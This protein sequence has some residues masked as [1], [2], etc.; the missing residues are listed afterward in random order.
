MWSGL[1]AV[2]FLA[3]EIVDLAWLHDLPT[4]SRDAARLFRVL[5]MSLTATVVTAVWILWRRIP[6]LQRGLASSTERAAASPEQRLSLAQWYFGLRWVALVVLTAVIVVATTGRPHVPP[7]SILP[8]WAAT[9]VLLFFDVGLLFVPERVRARPSVLLAQVIADVLL[10]S[11]L[12]HHAGG[13]ANPFASFLVF[14][15]VIASIVLDW[16]RARIATGVTVGVIV[17]QAVLESTGWAPPACVSGIGA[18]CN[19]PDPLHL[20]AAG[21]GLATLSAGCALFTVTLVGTLARERDQL[22]VARADL[23]AERE[24]LQSI[25]A[26]MADAVIFADPKGRVLMHN[27]AAAKLFESRPGAGEDLK[28]CHDEEIWALL[29]DKLAHPASHEHHPVLTLDDR[30]YEATYARVED[31]QGGLAGVVM[32]ARDITERQRAQEWRMRKERMAVVGKLAAS[33]AHEINNPLGAIVL[34]TQHAL[35]QTPPSDPVFEHLSTVL[36]NANQASKIVRDLLTYARQRPPERQ[37]FTVGDLVREVARTLRHSADAAEV[38]IETK[39]DD[40][41][42]DELFGDPD[43]LRQVLVNLGLNAIDAMRGHG[44][45]LTL[46]VAPDGPDGIRLIV[47]DEGPG[48]AEGDREKVFQAFYTTKAE[49]TGLG[50]AV[51]QDIARA[52]GGT[53]E[54]ESE[55]GAGSTFSVRLPRREMPRASEVAA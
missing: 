26:C 50:L 23:S 18:T 34:F 46:G 36:S 47:A 15:A 24:K 11:W 14:H 21:V 10:L 27:R 3:Y 9:A 1:M 39:L 30:A 4:D 53:L 20:A 7:S 2:L 6:S 13:L 19:Q 40:E 55:V 12:L 54:L 28:V 29:L 22:F 16:R 43:Q 38:R 35:K 37:V 25:L 49:G 41:A 51:A 45:T 52:H 17:I 33:L 42:P 44:G 48:I 31:R 5:A 32:V 8:L